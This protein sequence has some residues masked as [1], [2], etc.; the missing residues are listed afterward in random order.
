VSNIPLTRST[1]IATT[2]TSQL[3]KFFT[4][5]EAVGPGLFNINSSALSTGPRYQISPIH[6]VRLDYQFQHMGFSSPGGTSL[7]SITTHG[8]M[9][10]WTG[11]ITPLVHFELGGGG[12]LLSDGNSFQQTARAQVQYAARELTASALYS[13]S[14]VPSYFGAAGALLSDVISIS[15]AYNLTPE[16]SISAAYNYST[17]KLLSEFPLTIASHGPLGTVTYRFRNDMVA[18]LTVM[19]FKMDFES[20]GAPQ[21][22][23]RETVTFSIRAEWN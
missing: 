21:V 15:G 11:D 10:T 17:N 2:Y 14:L 13:R 23:N 16:W 4:N 6:A 20:A 18:A 22:I 9:F 12:A 3:L 19:Y 7:G 8:S 5:E 1:S